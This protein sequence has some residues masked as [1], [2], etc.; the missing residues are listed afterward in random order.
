MLQWYAECPDKL[1]DEI[2]PNGTGQLGL[3]TREPIGVV[4]AVVPWN[5]PVLMAA[6]KLAPALAT[7]NSVIL[8][9]AEQSPLTAIRTSTS[10]PRQACLR[11]ACYQRAGSALARQR[12]GAWHAPQAISVRLYRLG[13]SGASWCPRRQ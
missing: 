7:G 4:G 5:F 10:P 12:A 3:I 2:A 6:W 11:R 8:K 1:Y 13:R 9:P